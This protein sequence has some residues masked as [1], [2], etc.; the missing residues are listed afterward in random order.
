MTLT[1]NNINIYTVL[2]FPKLIINRTSFFII[3]SVKPKE[4][5]NGNEIWRY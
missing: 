5:K 4:I 2:A 3:V 1:V